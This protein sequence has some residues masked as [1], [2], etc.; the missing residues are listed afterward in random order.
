MVANIK[1]FIKI[2][3]QK[4]LSYFVILFCFLFFPG[5]LIFA[6]LDVFF[7][8]NAENLKQTKLTQMNNVLEYLNKYSNNKRYF[9]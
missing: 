4:F 5:F 7:E 8:N 9:H 6:S 3:F 1:N 2:Y